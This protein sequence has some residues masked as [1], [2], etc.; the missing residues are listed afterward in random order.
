MRQIGI[1]QNRLDEYRCTNDEEEINALREI[2]QEMIL[3]GLSRTDF[4]TRA[5]FHGGTQLRIFEGIRR[6]SED[7]DF[8]LLEPDAG[9]ELKPYL[10][11]VA[12]ELETVGVSLEVKDKSKASN[13]VKKGFLKDDSL[14]RILE[15]RYV[16]RKG[17]LGTPAKIAIKLEVD[18]NPPVG[19]EYRAAPLVFPFPAS[20]RSFDRASSFAGKIHAL[21]CRNYIK[22]RDWFDFIWYVGRRSSINHA[23]LT[24]ALDQQGQWTG[25][26]VTT[27][28]EWVRAHLMEKIS[29]MD[30]N[31][32][33]RDVRPFVYAS[34][35]PSLDLWSC[36]FFSSLADRIGREGERL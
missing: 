11:K 31:A 12:A 34:D 28:D 22:G 24:A 20:V 35:R 9:F 4:F 23:L 29:V 3:A 16:G 18:A 5:A 26:H 7:L 6:Y 25:Q 10:D 36:D 1:L 2:L 15:L 17:T 14:V 21:L 30:W 8:A 27:T 32:A 19:A 33:I 13:T